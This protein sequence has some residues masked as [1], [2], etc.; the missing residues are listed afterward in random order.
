MFHCSTVI[1]IILRAGNLLQKD[2][3]FVFPTP[4]ILLGVDIQ[5][6]SLNKNPILDLTLPRFSSPGNSLNVYLVAT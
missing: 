5:T 1:Q 2:V 6:T 3:T 4:L